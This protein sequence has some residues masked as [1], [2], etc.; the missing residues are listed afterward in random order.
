MAVVFLNSTE[1]AQFYNFESLIIAT[2]LIHHLE[3]NNL[4][5]IQL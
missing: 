5:L 3:N 2:G 1:H 4:I